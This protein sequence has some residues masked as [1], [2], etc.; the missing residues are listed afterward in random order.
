M[1]PGP[2][3]FFLFA[4]CSG[5]PVLWL[6]PAVLHHHLSHVLPKSER[7]KLT[8]YSLNFECPCIQATVLKYSTFVSEMLR[9]L[10]FL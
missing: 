5:L 9:A 7:A 10:S 4:C 2:T 6:L 8:R 3:R 1:R